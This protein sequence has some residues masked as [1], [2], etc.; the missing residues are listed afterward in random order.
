MHGLGNSSQGF[1]DVFENGG[2]LNHPNL[3]VVLPTAPCKPVSCRNGSAMNSW[4]D[5][6]KLSDE[7]DMTGINMLKN[8]QTAELATMIRKE[9][10]QKDLVEASDLQIKLV[11]EEA[12]K[13]NGD[14]SK[15]IIGGFSQG[16]MV[17]LTTHMRYQGAQPLCGVIGLS[18]YL[19]WD[20]AREEPSQETI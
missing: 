5:I 19:V 2:P 14:F 20:K 18:G 17:S 8:G 3:R 4:F 15:I 1:E 13:L 6:Y 7:S 9:H 10:S 12:A 11:E 16:C